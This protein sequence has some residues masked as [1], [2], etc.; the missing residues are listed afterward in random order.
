MKTKTY[1][2]NYKSLATISQFIIEQAEDAGFSPK[3]VYA[4]QIAV[5]EACSN[6]IDHAYGGENLGEITIKFNNFKNKIQIILID[7]GKPFILEDVPEPDLTSPLETRKERGL[8]VF[9]MKNFM[10]SVLFEFSQSEGNILT[11]EKNKGE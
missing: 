9:F 5:D 2:A 7:K 3:D 4:I 6:I 10:D 1:P 11:M 8:G